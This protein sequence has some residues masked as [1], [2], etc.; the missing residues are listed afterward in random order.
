MQEPVKCYATNPVNE[1]DGGFKHSRTIMSA[2]SEGC[3]GQIVPP[4]KLFD[5]PAA[6]YGILRGTENIIQQCEWVGRDYYYVDH[7]YIGSGHYSGYYRVTKNARQAKIPNNPEYPRDRQEKLGVKLRPWRRHG[8]HVLVIPIT[9]AVGDFYGI[10][11][12]LWLQTAMSEVAKVTDRQI[13]TKIKGLGN[14]EDALKD[15]WCVVT[16][17]SNVAVNALIEGIPVI[18]LG[19]SVCGS[20]SWNF[21]DIEKPHWPEREWWL[22]AVCYNQWT[23]DEMRSGECWRNVK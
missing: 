9:G 5:G 11:Q 10:Q 8:K 16:H 3:D 6:M 12:D 22:R 1:K 20:M 23:L 19:E 2:F 17:S 18:T 13:Q 14:L 21:P 7:G 4:I 15:C